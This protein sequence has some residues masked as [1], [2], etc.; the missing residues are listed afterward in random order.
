MAGYM[1]NEIRMKFHTKDLNLQMDG[2]Q[3]YVIMTFS[4]VNR[5]EFLVNE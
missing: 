5:M 4:S 2:S 3:T 1:V